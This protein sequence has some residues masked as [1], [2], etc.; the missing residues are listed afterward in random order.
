M[1]GLILFFNPYF[2]FAWGAC[3]GSF[4]NVVIYRYPLGR[5]VVSPGSA[6]PSCAKEIAFYDN[7]PILSWFILLGKCRTCKAKFSPM[8]AI[9]EALFGLLSAAAILLH[10]HAWLAAF[11]LSSLALAT[12]PALYLLVRFKKAPW[13]LWCCTVGFGCLYLLDILRG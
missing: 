3:W 7:I 2:F 11:A 9:N 10:P 8:Y 13:Y 1:E 12:V 4:L 5:S 6:C